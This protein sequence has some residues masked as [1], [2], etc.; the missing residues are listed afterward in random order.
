M[1][2][3]VIPLAEPVTLVSGQ[4]VSEIKIRK[5]QQASPLHD[6]THSALIGPFLR[7]TSLLRD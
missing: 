4:V 2:D 3:D 6:P 1:R 7:Y 5:G